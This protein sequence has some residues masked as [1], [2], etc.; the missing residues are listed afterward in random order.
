MGLRIN[1]NISSVAA[2]RNLRVSER[3]QARSLERL[4]T[5]LRIN[6]AADDPSGL[7]V[8]EQLRASLR[9]IRQSIDNSERDSNLIGTADA[10]LSEVEKLLLDIRE[11]VIFALNTGGVDAEQ[12]EAEQDNIDGALTAIDRI[13][14][15]T[16]FANSFVL[17]GAGNFTVTTQS[18]EI[19]DITIRN[20]QFVSRTTSQ[21]FN[22]VVTASAQRATTSG[23]AG[24]VVASFGTAAA[25]AETAVVRVTG[26]LGA[27]DIRINGG[28]TAA[29]IRSAI[30]A[31]QF[32]TGVYASSSGELYSNDFGSNALVRVE[33]VSGTYDG[34]TGG[35]FS[36]D[37]GQN[38][39]AT[40]NGLQVASQGVV[41]NLNSNGVTGELTLLSPDSLNGNYAA[42]V[43]FTFRVAPNTGLR[44]QLNAGNTLN[45][46]ET[47]GI[48]SVDTTILGAVTRVVPTLATATT[49]SFGGS[50]QSLDASGAN[51]LSLDPENS[52]R[53]VDGAIEQVSDLRAFLGSFQAKVLDA[54]VSA[55]EVAFE[56]LTA[57]ESRIRDL[58]F[59][60]ET[61]EFT[62]T[63]ILFQAGTAVL[64]QS[65]LI[66]QSVL[67]LL[68]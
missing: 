19:A 42:S 37:R 10:A 53:V 28:D 67:T 60:A 50:L 39:S 11:S 52:L 56:N 54:N 62:R 32:N 41:I 43:T 24:G 7:V 58:D 18:N 64:A 68:Q 23:A 33:M 4:S 30:N 31:A 46:Q 2:L 5:G 25:A 57:T 66:P 49:R 14:N 45:D 40:V 63:Q 20:M 8:S 17:N 65:N 16:K 15:G 6:S 44:F 51:S 61:S 13:A 26:S 35:T 48:K 29:R 36:E 38:V 21:T 59:A 27:E 55:L 34:I 3:S 1:N 9:G 47:I 12:I 22:I